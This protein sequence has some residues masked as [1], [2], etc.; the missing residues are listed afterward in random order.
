MSRL[1]LTILTHRSPAD[2]AVEALMQGVKEMGFE[3]HVVSGDRDSLLAQVSEWSVLPEVVLIERP[4]GTDG[5]SMVRAFGDV[6]P[7]GE[8]DILLANVPNDI[9]TYRSLKKLGITEIFA[10]FP[11]IIELRSTL[12]SILMRETR[13][14]GIDPRRVVYV[15]SACGGAGGT[16]FA[17][18][19][20]NGFAQEGR[21]TLLLDMDIF[22]APASYMF[23]IETETPETS[24]LIDI[25]LNPNRVDALFL[26]RSIQKASENL[27]YLSARRRS[28]SDE[29][30]AEA[31][32]AIVA[33]AQQNFDMVVVD[34]PWR[35]NPEPQYGLVNGPS[36]IVTLP[37]PQGLLGFAALAKELASVSMKTGMFGIINKVG[38]Q[39]G[40]EL[41]EKVFADS[42]SGK[43]FVFPYNPVEAGRL[44]FEQKTINQAGG[45][46]RRFLSPIE[47]SLPALA[48]T[49][50]SKTGVS[51][52]LEPKKPSG[53]FAGLF[54]K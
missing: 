32:S 17:H 26:E 6:A 27:F 24:G 21:R 11:D 45:K 48:Q 44:F 28:A 33:R 13:E 38:E 1:T 2:T 19:F 54:K 40:N 34:T 52:A 15:W 53:L 14:L 16:T 37:N 12:D 7:A 42:F 22:A 8:A 4:E 25:L 39:K 49:K 3:V 43:T 18:A 9:A 31:V 30:S 35:C 46:L 10:V 47:A 29:M 20:A 50:A 41:S 36:Y 51:G 23:N 5:E